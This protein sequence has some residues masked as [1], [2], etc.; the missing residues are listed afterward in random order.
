VFVVLYVIQYAVVKPFGILKFEIMRYVY[1]L[2]MKSE[3]YKKKKNVLHIINKM[4]GII[5]RGKKIPAVLTES[6]EIENS[7]Q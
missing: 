3:K 7:D 6:I 4:G 5:K 2:K 1:I